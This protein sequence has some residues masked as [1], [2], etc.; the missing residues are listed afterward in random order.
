MPL[1]LDCSVTV[2]WYFASEAT[3][4]TNELLAR[5]GREP[6]FVPALWCLEFVSAIRAA[7]RRR[8]I[9]AED[10]RKI[11]AQAARLPLEIDRTALGI[12]ELS[13]IVHRFDLTPYDGLYLELA[14]RRQ[15]TLATLDAD[16]VR[17][18]R[19]AKVPIVTDLARFPEAL[20]PKRASRR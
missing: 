8:R 13:D 16:L 20:P 19:S 6:M 7:E 14:R 10:R 1:L 18:A 2:A 5:V 11:L 17:A 15:L 9:D 4:F 12:D 3:D